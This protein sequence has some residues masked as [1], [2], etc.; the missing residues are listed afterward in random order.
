ML[1]WYYLLLTL[2]Y[3]KSSNIV[4]GQVTKIVVHFYIDLFL[5]FLSKYDYLHIHMDLVVL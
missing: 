2:F 5:D 1:L 3:V 4:L